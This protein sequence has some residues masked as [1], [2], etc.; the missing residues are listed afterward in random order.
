[1]KGAGAILFRSASNKKAADAAWFYP[2]LTPEFRDLKNYIAFYPSHIDACYVAD[3]QIKAQAGDFY[4][5]WITDNIGGPFKGEPG[6]LGG[7]SH[8]G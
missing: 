4:G 2:S 1:M 3:E 5:G 7:N 6:T 8:L